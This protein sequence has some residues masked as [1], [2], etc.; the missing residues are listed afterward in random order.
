[1]AFLVQV[2]LSLQGFWKIL[3]VRCTIP[4]SHCFLTHKKKAYTLQCQYLAA[5]FAE[6]LIGT[7]H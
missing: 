5:A 6:S 1:M 7:T 4:L 2:S 3:I